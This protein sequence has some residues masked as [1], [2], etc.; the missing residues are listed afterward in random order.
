MLIYAKQPI[1]YLI[2]HY[3]QKIKTLYLAKE[4]DKKEYSRL[5]KMGFPIKR[6]PNEAAVKMSKNA[7]HQGFLA[8]VEE[9]TLHEFK[10]F[11]DKDFVLVLAGLTDVGNIGAI[12]RSAYALGVDAIVACGVKKLNLEPLLRT[13][14]G[15]LF[16]MPFALE[17]NI[18]NVLNDLKMSGFRSYGADMGGIDIR[19]AEIVKKRVLVLGNEGEGLTSRVSSK[20]DTIVSIKMA[21]DFDS[22]NVSV[23]GAI[24]MDR[25]RYE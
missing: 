19:Q 17:H 2:N 23:A 5:M 4:L 12:V 9:Y 24:L 7:N 6:I 21:H 20:L 14:T 18:H 3:P 15:A 13:S 8:E 10:S 16:D 1:Y 22:L 11:L 25:M